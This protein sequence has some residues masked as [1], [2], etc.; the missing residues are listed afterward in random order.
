MTKPL[1]HASRWTC[2]FELKTWQAGVSGGIE[3]RGIL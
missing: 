2:G 3:W 1:A